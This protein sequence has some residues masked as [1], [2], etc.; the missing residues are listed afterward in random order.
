MAV[1][2]RNLAWPGSQLLRVSVTVVALIAMQAALLAPWLSLLGGGRSSPALVLMCGLALIGLAAALVESLSARLNLKSEIRVALDVLILSILLGILTNLALQP[3]IGL[4]PLAGLVRLV[5]VDLSLAVLPFE[6]IMLT[7]ALLVW[8]NGRRQAAG[9]SLDPGRTGFRFRAGVLLFALYIA[10]SKLAG[11]AVMPAT[12]PIFF[13]GSLLAMSL[14]RVERMNRLRGAAETPFTA[15][16]IANLLILFVATIALGLIFGSALQSASAYALLSLLQTLLL[17]LIDILYVVL[18]PIFI[19]LSPLFAWL[20]QQ[21]AMLFVM[22]GRTIEGSL[23]G[24]MPPP[25]GELFQD[26]PPPPFVADLLALLARL[27]E[28]WP[29]VRTLVIVLAVLLLLWFTLRANRKGNSRGRSGPGQDR[30]EGLEPEGF[31][32][33]L[34][35]RLES[36]RFELERWSRAVIGGQIMSAI[37]IRRIYGRMLKLAAENGRPRKRSETPI[38]FE[39]ALMRLYPQASASVAAITRAYIEVRYGEFPED[40]ATVARVRHA[41]STV[42]KTAQGKLD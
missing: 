15:G 21:I 3:D 17:L 32:S 20:V 36:A 39:R 40:P 30:G 42:R 16:W 8:R 27:G 25:A 33:G 13:G 12:L 11:P 26:I 19:V 2:K 22:L 41:W 5:Q 14:T 35:L 1:A 4:A 7:A 34:R 23:T 6:V 9:E 24:E 10:A 18:R 31:L 28:L 38:E 29:L 37:A